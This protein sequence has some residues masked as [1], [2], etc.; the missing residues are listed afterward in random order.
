M[1]SN[2]TFERRAPG[3]ELADE[4]RRAVHVPAVVEPERG[5]AAVEQVEHVGVDDSPGRVG[6]DPGRGAALLRH[7]PVHVHVALEV[8]ELGDDRRQ[9]ARRE[10]RLLARGLRVEEQVFDAGFE[11]EAVGRLRGQIA[12]GEEGDDALV[13]HVI[14]DDGARDRGPAARR[15]EP[16]AVVE[17]RVV[18]QLAERHRDEGVQ[19]NAHRAEGREDRGEEGRVGVREAS[20]EGERERVAARPIPVAVEQVLEGTLRRPRD[21]HDVVGAREQ[22]V[23]IESHPRVVGIPLERAVYGRADRERRLDAGAVHRP[24]E[25]DDEWVGDAEV[26][27]A[28][29]GLRRRHDGRD[30]RDELHVGEGEERIDGRNLAGE[31]GV[32]VG[33]DGERERSGREVGEV[34]EPVV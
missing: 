32:T 14:G 19:L 31:R 8:V 33:L 27:V 7:P 3:E 24:A 28:L 10:E 9:R 15:F 22:R 23:G 11:H 13:A 5:A 34:V 16:D 18:D 30:R 1:L 25:V 21:R 6:D 29:D 20:H 26:L 17:R 4:P 12:G 2:R